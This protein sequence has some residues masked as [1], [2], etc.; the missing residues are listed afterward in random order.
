MAAQHGTVKGKL[1]PLVTFPRRRIP[2][3]AVRILPNTRGQ[4]IRVGSGRPSSE[5]RVLHVEA[6]RQ[7]GTLRRL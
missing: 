2:S 1:A 4:A 3:E 7:S 6:D 5:K